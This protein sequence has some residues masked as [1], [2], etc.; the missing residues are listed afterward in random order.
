MLN[1]RCDE[2]ALCG[3]CVRNHSIWFTLEFIG[4]AGEWMSGWLDGCSAAHVLQANLVTQKLIDWKIMFRAFID[5]CSSSHVTRTSPQPSAC[6]APDSPDSPDFPLLSC[7]LLTHIVFRPVSAIVPR[8]MGRD[9]FGFV[10]C[11]FQFGFRSVHFSIYLLWLF[12]HHYAAPP[13]RGG[14]SVW[15]DFMQN[16]YSIWQLNIC[17]NIKY[18][19]QI[20]ALNHWP[21]LLEPWFPWFP[22]GIGFGLYEMDWCCC[23]YIKLQLYGNLFAQRP[24]VCVFFLHIL[25]TPSDDY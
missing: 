10:G 21:L 20:R 24:N 9:W 16:P 12:A 4:Q 2:V 18:W 19:L 11:C 13:L 25:N 3:L 1:S 5:S 6:P 14:L 8:S 17:A 22:L 23:L 7:W 15:V